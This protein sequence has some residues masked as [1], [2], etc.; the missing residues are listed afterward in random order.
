M[1]GPEACLTVNF[2]IMIQ[3]LWKF[4]LFLIQTEVIL[5]L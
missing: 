4:D 2:S 3:I 1:C 5:L